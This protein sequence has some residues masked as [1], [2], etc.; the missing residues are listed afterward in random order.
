MPTDD[1]Q[2]ALTTALAEVAT[3]KQE[4][5][6]LKAEIQTE[7]CPS[8]GEVCPAGWCGV[9]HV[10]IM[11]DWEKGFQR[12]CEVAAQNLARAEQA[13][14]E[15]ATLKDENRKNY[16]REKAAGLD[17]QTRQRGG[18]ITGERGTPDA[19]TTRVAAGTKRPVDEPHEN[20]SPDGDGQA[21]MTSLSPALPQA[22]PQSLS[23]LRGQKARMQAGSNPADSLTLQQLRAEVTTLHQAH[24]WQPIATVPDWVEFIIGAW[25][26]NDGTFDVGELSREA[27]NWVSIVGSREEPTHWMPLPAAPDPAGLARRAAR[28]HPE[29]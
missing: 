12:I 19:D 3:L 18:G 28:P 22:G 7:T 25:L 17:R 10:P 26:V 15:V 5:L 20:H 24:Q 1:L 4:N 11:T 29:P 6:K 23:A 14:A 8:C 9:C 13:E 21:G 16:E 27:M 2:A